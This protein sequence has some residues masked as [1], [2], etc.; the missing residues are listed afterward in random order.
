MLRPALEPA[1]DGA[2]VP[3][4]LGQSVPLTTT[5]HAENDAVQGAS[6]VGAF[7]AG[8]LG[9]GI[10]EEDRF[11]ALPQLIGDLPDRIQFLR[12]HQQG[13]HKKARKDAELDTSNKQKDSRFEIIS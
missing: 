4:L 7:A 11:N 13:T 1:V 10:F 12:L 5:A 8:G 3:E 9:W 2:I 6:P